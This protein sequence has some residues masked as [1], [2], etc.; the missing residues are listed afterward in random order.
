MNSDTVQNQIRQLESLRAQRRWWQTGYTLALFL[1]A[2]FSIF[3]LRSAIYGLLTEGETQ[4]SFVTN[5]SK[6]LNDKAAPQIQ[7]MASQTLREIDFGAEVQKLNKRTPELTQAT[8]KEIQTLGDNL[9]KH[10]KEILDTTLVAAVKGREQKIRTMY[11]DVTPEQLKTMVDTLSTQAQEQAISVS[12]SL[13]GPHQKALNNIIADLNRIE[14]ADG[15]QAKGEVPSWEMALMIFDIAR[16]DLKKL[17]PKAGEP[18]TGAASGPKTSDATPTS[19][20]KESKS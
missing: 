8:L 1:I 4:K 7:E 20:N 14:S 6:R 19:G 13:F 18:K 3:S 10:G 15:A 16:E 2:V 11:P 5:L 12:D 17:E 9:P